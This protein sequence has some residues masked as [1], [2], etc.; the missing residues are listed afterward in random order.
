MAPLDENGVPKYKGRK[1]GRKP[2]KR[3]RQLNPNRQKRQHTAYTLFVKESYPS[4]RARHPS[5]QSKDIIAL[6]ARQWAAVSETEKQAWKERALS[7][8]QNEEENIIPDHHDV[9]RDNDGD[10]RHGQGNGRS[11]SG[12]KNNT[13]EVETD[14]TVGTMSGVGDDHDEGIYVRADQRHDDEI[15]RIGDTN[16]AEHTTTRRRGRSRKKP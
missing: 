5:F 14:S 1:R 2:K 13:R 12:T 16:T 10:V 11:S 4:L 6:V 8:H 3:K 7:T 15:D 9:S